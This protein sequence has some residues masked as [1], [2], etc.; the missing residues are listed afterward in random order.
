[1]RKIVLSM[2]LVVVLVGISGCTNKS[3]ANTS[4][5]QGAKNNTTQN[6]AN[7]TVNNTASNAASNTTSNTVNNTEVNGNNVKE[8]DSP[9]ANNDNSDTL[10]DLTSWNHPVKYVF[11]NANVNV[12]KVVFKNNK[13]FPIFYVNLTK[14][15]DDNNKIYYKNLI[16]Q[17]ATANGYWDYEIIDQT[18]NIDIKVLCDRLNRSVKEVTNNGENTYFST[19]TEKQSGNTD[20][21]M[22]DYLVNN[23]SEVKSFMQ[24]L[25]NN[26]NGVKGITYVEREPDP[27][28]TDLYL[29]NYYGLYVGESH[30]DHNVNIYRF[31]INKDTKEILFYDVVNDK[32]EN[33]SNWRTSK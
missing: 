26:K 3:A 1:M 14:N 25:Q 31:A 15:L 16:K 30:S 28:S 24:S 33:L 21:Q 27:N 22:V 7:N 6:T 12:T 10:T 29:K 13:T 4:T 9:K 2:I 17:V 20:S 11:K 5:T 18:K 32:Y 23:V 8:I 19:T